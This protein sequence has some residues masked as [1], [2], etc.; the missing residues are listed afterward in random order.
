LVVSTTFNPI[1]DSLAHDMGIVS[2]PLSTPQCTAK[3]CD[4]RQFALGAP[5]VSVKQPDSAAEAPLIPKH[6]S[7]PQCLVTPFIC[8]PFVI[9]DKVGVHNRAGSNV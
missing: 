1:S 5:F 9:Y 7:V 2:T 3:N 6:N 4:S 8:L